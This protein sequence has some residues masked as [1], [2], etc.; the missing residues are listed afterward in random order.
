MLLYWGTEYFTLLKNYDGDSSYWILY[1]N[2]YTLKFNDY[3]E[4]IEKC[5]KSHM[6]PVLLF[7]KKI[8]KEAKPHDSKCYLQDED[9]LQLLKFAEFFDEENDLIYK[10][11]IYDRYKLRPDYIEKNLEKDEEIEFGKLKD[12]QE[13]KKNRFKIKSDQD[14]QNEFEDEINRLGNNFIYA[15]YIY[16][17]ISISISISIFI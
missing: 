2:S 5:L 6:H 10:S 15:L 1:N 11:N 13:I 8:P 4:L 14:Y 3:K 16:I 9:M 7:Y 17:S 12:F